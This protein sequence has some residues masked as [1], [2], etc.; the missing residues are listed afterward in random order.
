MLPGGS[1]V[2]HSAPLVFLTFPSCKSWNLACRNNKLIQFFLCHILTFKMSKL[3][4][5]K[6]EGTI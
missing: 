4:I 1:S 5:I 3:P 2:L 6:P